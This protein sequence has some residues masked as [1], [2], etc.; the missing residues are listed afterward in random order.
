MGRHGSSGPPLDEFR[1]FPYIA[2]V[3]ANSSGEALL[4]RREERPNGDG[5]VE[6]LAGPS[7]KSGVRP[8]PVPFPE[9]PSRPRD[10]LRTAT[11][12]AILVRPTLTLLWQG[13][14]RICGR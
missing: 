14:S 2:R 13:G 7:R 10:A 4:A 1:A 12:T 5:R 11:S 6:F 9:T 8:G 3:S